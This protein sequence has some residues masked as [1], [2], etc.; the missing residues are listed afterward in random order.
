MFITA[1]KFI[2]SNYFVNEISWGKYF[3]DILRLYELCTDL[4]SCLSQDKNNTFLSK[5][6]LWESAFWNSK[7]DGMWV[8]DVLKL[9][10]DYGMKSRAWIRGLWFVNH[11]SISWS[12]ETKICG[13]SIFFQ[14]VFFPKYDNFKIISTVYICQSIC[15]GLNEWD[16]SMEEKA[17]L[18]VLAHI[19]LC[20]FVN[21]NIVLN[22]Y[23]YEEN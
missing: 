11:K 12:H 4:L 16:W 6:K 21:V 8:K 19:K 10:K 7:I 13:A 18:N 20:H 22:L 9:E 3:S 15:L 23:S 1:W 17:Q 2:K 14:I 5:C